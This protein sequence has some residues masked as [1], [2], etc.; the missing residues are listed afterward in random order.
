MA[1]QSAFSTITRPRL[2]IWTIVLVG[3]AKT[4]GFDTTVSVLTDAAAASG[5]TVAMEDP[6]H[7]VR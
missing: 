3:A 2:M 7:S 5:F 6:S 1:Y 4:C